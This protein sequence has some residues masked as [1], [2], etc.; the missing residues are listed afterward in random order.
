MKKIGKVLDCIGELSA[1]GIMI[2]GGVLI[3]NYGL[4]V[5]RNVTQK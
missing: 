4:M 1:A 3:C 5:L 2:G